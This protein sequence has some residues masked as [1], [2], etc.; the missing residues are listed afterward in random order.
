MK[1]DPAVY[2][3]LFFF[4]PPRGVRTKD[5]YSRQQTTTACALLLCGRGYHKCGSSTVVLGWCKRQLSRRFLL[6]E[7]TYATE[8][9]CGATHSFELVVICSLTARV[10]S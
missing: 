10:T 3:L 5:K 4:F 7:S 9:N 6:G 1:P 2:F 8:R